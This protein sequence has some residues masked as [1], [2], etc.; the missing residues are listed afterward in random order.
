MLTQ[1][2]VCIS[3]RLASWA[4][5]LRALTSMTSNRCNSAALYTSL[6]RFGGERLTFI[7][8]CH[9]MWRTLTAKGP[10]MTQTAQEQMHQALPSSRS[11]GVKVVDFPIN[12]SSLRGCGFL[13]FGMEGLVRNGV[14][15]RP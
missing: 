4:R 2:A 9:G 8:D 12:A 6:R 11:R 5:A 10:S 1:A 7:N 14:I 15:S 3:S 13:L